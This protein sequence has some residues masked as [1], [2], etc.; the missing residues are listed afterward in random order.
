MINE[1]RRWNSLSPMFKF[2]PD[3]VFSSTSSLNVETSDL[4]TPVDSNS[5]SDSD[6]GSDDSYQTAEE[7]D[8]EDEDVAQGPRRRVKKDPLFLRILIALAKA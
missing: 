1:S 8:D 6:S 2:R 3:P 5:D 4:D 7:G